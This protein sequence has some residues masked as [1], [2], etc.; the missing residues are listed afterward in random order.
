MR[1]RHR[2]RPRRNGPMPGSDFTFRDG[3]RLIRFARGAAGE[4]LDLIEQQG[5]GGYVLL[6]T[7][8]A[9]RAAPPGLEAAAEVVLMVPHC[10]VPEAAAAVRGSVAGRPIVALGGGRVVDAGKAI[11][12]ADGLRCAA[13]PTTLA[14]S[15]FTPFHRMPA[16]VEDFTFVRPVLAVCDP[17]LMASSPMPDLAA[18]AMNAL[19]HAVESLYAPGANPVAE[20]AALRSAALLAR[21]LPA[22]PPVVEDAALAAVLAGW[23]VGTTGLALH[24]ALCQT[25]VR[26]AGTP[27]ARTN[28]VMLPH[29]VAFMADRAPRAIAG[30]AGALAADGEDPTTAAPKV[31]V[32]AALAG[33]PTLGALGVKVSDLPAIASAAAAHPGMGGTPGGVTEQE[34]GA[35]LARAS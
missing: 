13:I 31:A 27:H 19:A 3:D 33:P 12:G 24:H 29:S 34:L 23:A 8:R 20:G 32:L 22:D 16:G 7:E 35:L 14:G 28:A 1:R 6:T 18:T 25:I 30:L 11:A 15:P 4:S 5:L 2:R 9:S 17:A 21:A 10:P 26:Q